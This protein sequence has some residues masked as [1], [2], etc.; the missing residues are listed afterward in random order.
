MPIVAVT[1][2]KAREMMNMLAEKIT[3][4]M[5]QVAYVVHLHRYGSCTAVSR[6]SNG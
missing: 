6:S 4:Y 2:D 1:P 5:A 3:R